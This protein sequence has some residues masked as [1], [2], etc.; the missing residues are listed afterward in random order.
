VVGELLDKGVTISPSK[1]ARG[2]LTSYIQVWPTKARARCVDRLGW[3]DDAYVLPGEVIGHSSE[4]VV[5]QNAHAIEPAF[6]VKGTLEDW[7]TLA[8]G[9]AQANSRTVF[10]IST[11]FAGALLEP[12]GEESGGFH[13]RGPSSVGKTTALVL[14][15]SV[16]GKPETFKRSWRATTN[17]LEGVAA[18]HNDGLLVL[19]EL[20]QADAREVGE[21]AYLLANGKGK[22]RATRIGTARPSA[23]WRSLFLSAGEQS[24]SALM[25]QAGKKSTAGQEIRLAEIDAD[26]GAGMGA[27]EELHGYK[28]AGALTLALKDAAEAFH[29]VVGVEWLRRLAKD[30]NKLPALLANGIRQFAAELAPKNAG[31]Q[32]ERV[33]RRF[34]LVGVAGE[35]ATRYCLTGWPEGEA[36]NATSKCFASWLQ[37]FGG[38]GNREERELLAQV[39]AFFEAH[40]SSRFENVDGNEQRIPN[41]AGFYRLG[42]EGRREL[43]VLPETFRREVCAGFDTKSAISALQQHKWLAPGHSDR[44]TQRVR[45]AGMGPTWVYAFTS[46]WAGGAE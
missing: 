15:A 14:A 27:V 17:G 28:D 32:I 41:R 40:G 4:T 43:L 12:A 23:S 25:M 1:K 24:L 5:F 21:A 16:W 13:L 39:K 37:Q 46:M 2:F 29:G 3:H 18:L 36:M 35:M 45:L 20:G 31:G 30:R 6:A 9:L 38:T 7:R 33:A 10:A 22:A 8:A 34:A 11:A 26:A 42:A 44:H 19:D